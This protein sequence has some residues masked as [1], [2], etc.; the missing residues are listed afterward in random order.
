MLSLLLGMLFVLFAVPSEASAQDL[1]IVSGATFSGSGRIRVKGNVVNS[2][3][4]E[5]TS[6]PGTLYLGGD[7]Q[8][9]GTDGAGA[10][11][12]NTLSLSGNGT[13]ASNVNVE[14]TD[15]L[16]INVGNGNTFDISDREITIGKL[17]GITSG[18]LSGNGNAVLRFTR[19]DG[20]VQIIP[21]GEYAAQIVLSG[22]GEKRLGGDLTLTAGSVTIQAGVSLNIEAGRTLTVRCDLNAIGSLVVD[23]ILNLEE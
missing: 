11:T 16:H 9:L 22:N 12:V 17:S 10:L 23:G 3:V 15:S 4:S 20:S 2:G 14:V 7:A 8:E 21:G 18:G 19:N 1:T 13:K 5:A 6:I